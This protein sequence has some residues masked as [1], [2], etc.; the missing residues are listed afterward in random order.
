[1]VNRRVLIKPLRGTQKQ[2]GTILKVDYEY[3][4]QIAQDV[5]HGSTFRI[6][7]DEGGTVANLGLYFKEVLAPMTSANRSR[8]GERPDLRSYSV[9]VTA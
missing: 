2:W 8:V 5:I 7:L 3:P 1:M 9:Q 4:F 6:K